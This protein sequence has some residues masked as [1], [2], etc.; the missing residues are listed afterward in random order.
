MG[1]QDLLPGVCDKCTPYMTPD[2]PPFPRESWPR[3]IVTSAYRLDKRPGE[4]IRTYA[5][6]FATYK[7][8]N[9][10][11]VWFCVSF[12]LF[13]FI[14][15]IRNHVSFTAY[16]CIRN[17]EKSKRTRPYTYLLFFTD[18]SRLSKFL[19]SHLPVISRNGWK[20]RV[21]FDY[22]LDRRTRCVDDED[23]LCIRERCLSASQR[24]EKSE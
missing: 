10:P 9:I 16:T 23:E 20:L 3:D 15:M 8:K 22:T 19:Q 11:S 13:F 18:I 1:G 14:V 6:L 2:F 17:F 7:V 24:R 12:K 5:I 4:N 21:R